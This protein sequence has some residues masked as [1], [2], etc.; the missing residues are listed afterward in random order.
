MCQ[1]RRSNAVGKELP[2]APRQMDAEASFFSIVRCRS[3]RQMVQRQGTAR[4]SRRR[5]CRKAMKTAIE[6]IPTRDGLNGLRCLHFRASRESGYFGLFRACVR[7][8]R[9]GGERV[10]SPAHARRDFAWVHPACRHL[11]LRAAVTLRVERK[12]G[13]YR[14]CFSVNA[15]SGGSR[16]A[17]FRFIGVSKGTEASVTIRLGAELHQSESD[18]LK[19]LIAGGKQPVCRRKAVDKQARAD[20]QPSARTAAIP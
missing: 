15:T 6:P 18:E 7:S 20:S 10:P 16:G 19:A 9:R 3:G 1:V 11:G 4:S 12:K 2:A 5:R 8:A 17:S 13:G 14:P